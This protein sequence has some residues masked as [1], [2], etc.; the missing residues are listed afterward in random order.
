MR[1]TFLLALI[2][3][4]TTNATAQ[5]PGPGFEVGEPFPNIAFPSVDGGEP[6]SISDFRGQKV[7]LHIFASW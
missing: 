6:R 4:T 2:L 3:M 5:R 7:V 1:L